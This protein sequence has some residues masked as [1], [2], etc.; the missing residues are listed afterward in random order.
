MHIFKKYTH[1]LINAIGLKYINESQESKSIDA[2]KKL[3]TKSSNMSSDEANI[4][5][6]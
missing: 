6:R 3:L 2:A 4:Y 1:E 5:V